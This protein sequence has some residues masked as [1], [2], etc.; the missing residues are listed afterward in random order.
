MWEASAVTSTL[1]A[2]P[3]NFDA[4]S[5]SQMVR[6]FVLRAVSPKE[7][8]AALPQAA[9]SLLT[10]RVPLGGEMKISFLAGNTMVPAHV[11]RAGAEGGQRDASG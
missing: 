1:D 3:F 8:R 10:T 5:A 2:L 4:C 9:L 7:A 11:A 6:P